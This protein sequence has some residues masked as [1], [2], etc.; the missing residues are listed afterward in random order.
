MQIK[1]GEYSV[2]FGNRIQI[3]RWCAAIVSIGII[4]TG[5]VFSDVSEVAIAFLGIAFILGVGAWIKYVEYRRFDCPQCGERIPEPEQAGDDF[6]VPIMFHCKKCNI[7]WDTG[8]KS[9]SS[10]T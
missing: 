10:T 4:I 2:R 9:I 6:G 5:H 7:R 3:M 1:K 8:I